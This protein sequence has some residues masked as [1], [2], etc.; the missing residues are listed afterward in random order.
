MKKN[1]KVTN[2]CM[3]GRI[4]LNRKISVK[5]YQKLINKCDWEEIVFGENF[6][7][8][9]SKKYDIR[10][11]KGI[12][13]HNKVKMPYVTLFHLGGIIIVGLI[14]KKEGHEVYDLVLKDLKKV[15]KNLLK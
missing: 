12:S 4:P 3:S 10:E 14:S 5:D 11:K 7:Y 8:R 9:Y 6:A 13:V 1:L 15:S 2:I